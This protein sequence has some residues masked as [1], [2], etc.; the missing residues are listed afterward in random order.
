MLVEL[1]AS[2]ILVLVTVLVH[3]VGLGVI[4]RLLG[5]EIH[6][7]TREHMPP[8]SFRA[9]FFTSLVVLGLITL[10]GIEIW[11][12]AFFYLAVGAL[13]DLGTAL[14]LSTVAYS[15]LGSTTEGVP[16]QWSSRSRESMG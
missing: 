13:D 3:A 4:G 14:Y 6:Q 2:T 9:L 8:L 5:Q 15:T 10:H 16:G 11:G 7:E 12:Y 1:G